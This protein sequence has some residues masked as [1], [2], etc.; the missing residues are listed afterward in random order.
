M[1]RRTFLQTL[2][3]GALAA[4]AQRLGLK[5]GIDAYS[6]RAFEWK[7]IR[8][9]D[10]VADLKLDSIQMSYPGDFE[11]GD[12]AYL[13]KVKDH[14]SRRGISID[15][16]IG[17]I[18][19]SSSGWRAANGSPEA[20]LRKG[21]QV[22][23]AVGGICM[24]VYIGGPADRRG[25]V[26]IDTHLENTIR[27]LRAV[28]NEA[29]DLGVKIAVE[30]HG[31]ITARE[32]LALIETAGKDYVASCLDT[33]NPMWLMED[34]LLTVE[35]LGP[36][37]VTTHIRDSAVFEHPRGAAFQWVALGDGSV[38][39]TKL[40]ALFKQL[41]PQSAVQLEIITGRPPQLLPYLEADYWK[42]FSKLPAADFARFVRLAKNG[43]PYQGPMVITGTGK[44]PPEYE[45]ALKEQQRL[46]LERSLTAARTLG[47]GLQR[48]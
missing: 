13:A 6:I 38:D 10:Y 28:R 19:S 45:S 24:R 46:D 9:I 30:N 31:D 27:A 41:C 43:R 47:V 42:V 36:Y 34:P 3:A 48:S 8:L 40:L 5:L 16:A 44:Q 11:S 37:T 20:Y 33:G 21:M 4:Q 22:T 15:G 12:P 25:P 23:K 2:G 29:L 26:S 18:C 7:A 32:T 1:L 14:A 39:F 17:C 35:V